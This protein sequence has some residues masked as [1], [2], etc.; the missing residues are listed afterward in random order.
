MSC[1]TY[2]Q[3]HFLGNLVL[4]IPYHQTPH[5]TYTH[6]LPHTCT[7]HLPHT[8]TH[9]LPH[10]CTHP[11]T[12]VVFTILGKG[13]FVRLVSFP[14]KSIRTISFCLERFCFV[15]CYEAAT[16]VTYEAATLVT[17]EAATLVTPTFSTL[18]SSPSR[19]QKEL[20]K[21]ATS[22]NMVVVVQSYDFYQYGSCRCQRYCT[23]SHRSP[24]SSNPSGWG[25][26]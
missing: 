8:C 22:T 10:T 2:F 6:H 1:A 13:I 24:S 16:L 26:G 3:G 12:T 5:T 4:C 17:Y 14:A 18:S 15:A 25:R 9:H 21:I 23:L 19:L 7:H 20:R 11:C